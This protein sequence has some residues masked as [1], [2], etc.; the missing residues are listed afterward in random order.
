MN[1]IQLQALATPAQEGKQGNI[2]EEHHWETPHKDFYL[3]LLTS[4]PRKNVN[5]CRSLEVSNTKTARRDNFKQHPKIYSRNHPY[6]YQHHRGAHK[7]RRLCHRLM[8]QLQ[9]YWMDLEVKLKWNKTVRTSYI[10]K[11]A[12]N[13]CNQRRNIHLWTILQR[14]LEFFHG[15]SVKGS[16][17]TRLSTNLFSP[18]Y[19]I[20][21]DSKLL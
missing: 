1:N 13:H 20:Q 21:P 8:W 17:L 3:I 16:S 11:E 10:Y 9:H 15:M 2:N 12:I 19:L 5:T 6:L 14:N 18:F 4:R 7:K